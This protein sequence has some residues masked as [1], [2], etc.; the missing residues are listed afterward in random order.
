MLYTLYTT[1]YALPHMYQILVTVNYLT[2]HCIDHL[3]NRMEWNN[4]SQPK[5]LCPSKQQGTAMHTIAMA[6][7]GY[8]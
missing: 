4:L 5:F 7:N 8:C 3:N 2:L 1:H 6:Y